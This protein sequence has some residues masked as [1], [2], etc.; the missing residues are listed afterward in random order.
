MNAKV[1][2]DLARPGHLAR[3]DLRAE[4]RSQPDDVINSS[5]AMRMRIAGLRVSLAKLLRRRWDAGEHDFALL[6]EARALLDSAL[7][8]FTDLVN[9][10]GPAPPLS[11]GCGDAESRQ[12]RKVEADAPPRLTERAPHGPAS[13]EDAYD[14]AMADRDLPASEQRLAAKVLE[15]PPPPPPPPPPSY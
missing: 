13:A 6:N 11:R 8:T 14:N 1:L 10:A 5:F 7:E 9:A 4:A 12:R 15:D 3:R 2:N